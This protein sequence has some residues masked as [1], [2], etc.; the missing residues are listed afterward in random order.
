[1]V[2]AR[3]WYKSLNSICNYAVGLIN[4]TAYS[5]LY[6]LLIRRKLI[7]FKHNRELN[8][9]LQ[10]SC[11]VVCEMMFFLYWEFTDLV[12]DNVLN[13]LVSETTELLYFDILILPY[14]VFNR[15]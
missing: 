14:L 13:V 6:A 2:I 12:K 15:R 9:T 5:L 3:S 10:A 7:S 4:F 8:M 1:M 11:M